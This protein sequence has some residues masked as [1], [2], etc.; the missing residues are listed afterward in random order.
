MG[1]PIP[2]PRPAPLFKSINFPWETV[3]DEVQEVD[4][5]QSYRLSMLLSREGLIC[6]PSSGMALQALL[7]VLQKVKDEDRLIEF[8]AADG[9]IHAVFTCCDLPYQYMDNYVQKLGRSAFPPI[10]NIVSQS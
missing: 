1:D 9:Q 2:G 10:G 8:A 4:S 3:V 5:P 6:G 7:N